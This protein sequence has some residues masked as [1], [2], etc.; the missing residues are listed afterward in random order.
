MAVLV[1]G[2]RHR[3]RDE[4]RGEGGEGEERQLHAALYS[5]EEEISASVREGAR[6]LAGMWA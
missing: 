2:L 4:M 5:S 6:L 1:E 3:S